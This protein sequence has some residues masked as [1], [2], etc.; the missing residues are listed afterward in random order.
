MTEYLFC[1]YWARMNV[2]QLSQMPTMARLPNVTRHIPSY[3]WMRPA[4]V[5]Q[6]A[7][8]L[9]KRSISLS[10]HQTSVALEPEF[11]AV[12]QAMATARGVTLAGLMR[13]IDETRGERPLASA[14]RVAA[15]AAAA[16]RG[17]LPD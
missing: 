6:G 17:P 15:L 2:S 16:A 7:M 9:Q 14:A 3:G 8:N 11:W 12:L 5:L 13:N 10:G 4:G 1:L